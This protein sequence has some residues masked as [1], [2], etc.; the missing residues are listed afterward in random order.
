MPMNKL[1]LAFGIMSDSYRIADFKYQNNGTY[2]AF[3][4]ASPTKDER[5]DHVFLTRD[6]HVYK[7]GVL[8]DV[9]YSESTGADGNITRVARTPSDHFPVKVVVGVE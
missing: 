8:T 7:Y 4:A 9:Y 5:I 2:N 1:S 3:G 6:F